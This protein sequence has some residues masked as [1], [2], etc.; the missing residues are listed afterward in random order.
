M[1]TN[2]LRDIGRGVIIALACCFAFCCLAL[3]VV[4]LLSG[5][6]APR[7]AAAYQFHPIT[8]EQRIFD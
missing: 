4:L 2:T 6:S 5:W 7:P 8:T 1:K 3:A